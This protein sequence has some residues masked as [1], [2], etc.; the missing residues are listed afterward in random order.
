MICMPSYIS[1]YN[2]NTVCGAQAGAACAKGKCVC[3]G[4]TV[5]A[6]CPDGTT[7][8]CTNDMCNAICPGGLHGKF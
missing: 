6:T 2:G 1:K 8:G 4:T 3:T 5:E 7:G